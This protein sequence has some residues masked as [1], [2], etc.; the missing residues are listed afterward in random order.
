MDR[1]RAYMNI[2]TFNRFALDTSFDEL[3]IIREALFVYKKQLEKEIKVKSRSKEWGTLCFMQ[4]KV[5]DTIVPLLE[6]NF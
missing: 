2:T 6:E 5:D 1:R 3:E 4:H